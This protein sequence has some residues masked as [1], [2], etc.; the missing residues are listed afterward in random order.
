MKVLVF[1]AGSS[2]QKC[3]LFD[4]GEGEPPLSP[5]QPLWRAHVDWTQAPDR[6]VTRIEANDEQV[7][8]S[9]SVGPRRD[10]LGR[11]LASLTQGKTKV[12]NSLAEVDIVGHRVVHV[13]YEFS[14]SI[15]LSEDVKTAIA[16]YVPLA[17]AHNSVQ[18]EGI[19]AIERLLPGVEQL[20][21]FDTAFHQSMPPHSSVYPIP[22][23]WFERG[24]RRYGFHGINHRY[25]TER[26]IQ[27]LG[28]KSESA[29]L[30]SC[31]LGNG[32]SLAAVRNGVSLDTTMG[33]T[34]LEGLM[35]G[36]R[37]GSIDPGLLIH[38][39]RRHGMGP[40]QLD[41]LLNGDSGLKGVS[42]LSGDMRTIVE[43]ASN[44]HRRAALALDLFTY[45]LRKAIGAATA[46]LEGLDALVFTA[47]IGENA[48]RV[49]KMT[50]TPLAYLGLRLDQEKNN[51]PF[52]E[53]DRDIA[54]Q[55]SQIRVLLI[56]AAE[57]WAIARD[58]RAFKQSCEAKG[59]GAPP[60]ST[61]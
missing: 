2:S 7:E 29:K 22:Y 52:E 6:A 3:A 49:R 31:H 16:R 5:R 50:C 19:E 61:W 10:L 42:G 8:E 35:M 51:A 34:P 60:E 24:I 54:S 58:C 44:G 40:D 57:E 59:K 11:I 38:L 18:L 27:I 36:S 39:M 47:G 13:G 17:P 37:C 45:R 28:C 15:P 20:A 21:V 56:R 4:T 26:A 25:C 46:A 32:C 41:R 12:L 53:A 43:A 55:D 1:N 48:A 30:I 23:E 14:Q 9:G 33:F